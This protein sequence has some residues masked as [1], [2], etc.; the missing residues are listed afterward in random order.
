MEEETDLLVLYIECVCVLWD[1][2]NGAKQCE[3]HSSSGLLIQLSCV[4]LCAIIFFYVNALELSVV[5]V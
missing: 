3:L 2:L 4:S 5:H 1:P